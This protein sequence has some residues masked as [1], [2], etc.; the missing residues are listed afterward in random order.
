MSTKVIGDFMA[1]G[2]RL[3]E[4]RKRLK[5]TQ[6]VFAQLGEIGVSSLKLYEGNEIEPGGIFL[7]LIADEGVD[8]QY[9][10]TGNRSSN[11]LAPEEQRLL[12]GFRGL[13]KATKRRT[14]AFVCSESGPVAIQKRI[15][16]KAAQAQSQ[17]NVTS[18]GGQAAGGN[19]TTHHGKYAGAKI[20]GVVEGDF[21]GTAHIQVGKKTKP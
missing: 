3:R 10:I 19:I 5:M 2:E 21:A 11:A 9:V 18:N 17:V 1:I 15:R 14:L 20:N 6:A 12:D 13:D 8:V 4:E 16:E 7:A